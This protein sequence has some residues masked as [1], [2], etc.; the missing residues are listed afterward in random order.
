MELSTHIKSVAYVYN[1]YYNFYVE[2][3]YINV[4]KSYKITNILKFKMTENENGV[5]EKY[6][7]IKFSENT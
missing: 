1:G 5:T 2:A 7:A 4:W 6:G 3:F